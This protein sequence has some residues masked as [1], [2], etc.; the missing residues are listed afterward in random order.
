[1]RALEQPLL[2]QLAEGS[3]DPAQLALSLDKNDPLA[4]LRSEFHIPKGLAAFNV[5]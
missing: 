5:R 2:A 3:L 4:H 1:M